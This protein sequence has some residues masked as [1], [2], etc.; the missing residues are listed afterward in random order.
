MRTSQHPPLGLLTMPDSTP[1]CPSHRVWSQKLPLRKEKAHSL[2]IREVGFLLL[3]L[4]LKRIL[5]LLLVKVSPPRPPPTWMAAFDCPPSR[6][7]TSPYYSSVPVPKA[8]R[9]RVNSGLQTRYICLSCAHFNSTTRNWPV[10]HTWKK[11]YDNN[12]LNSGQWGGGAWRCPPRPTTWSARRRVLSLRVPE[13]HPARSG[14]L[15]QSKALKQPEG[16]ME[17]PGWG[18]NKP[19]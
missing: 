3:L 2:E 10:S 4:L 15:M 12:G 17:L 9:P 13:R 14:T 18:G 19:F 6:R 16:Y 11:P 7:P 8:L 5:P 1:F